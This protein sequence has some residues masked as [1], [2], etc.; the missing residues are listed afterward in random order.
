MIYS[1]RT[2]RSAVFVDFNGDTKNLLRVPFMQGAFS[3]AWLQEL[4]AKHPELLQSEEIGSEYSQLVCIGREVKVGSG[5]NTGYIDN[6]YV[7]SSGHIVVV[8]TKLFRNQEARRTVVAQII[9]YAKDLQRWDCEDLDEVASDYSYRASG[10]AYRAFD[11]MLAA[12]YLT[13]AD[14]ARFIDAVNRN[15]KAANFLLLIVGDGIRSGVER[16]A[17]FITSYS[18]LPF[19]LGLLEL[20]VYQHSSG[21]VV[22]PNMLT[23]TSVIPIHRAGCEVPAAKTEA[24]VPAAVLPTSEF[25]KIFAANG[26]YDLETIAAFVSDLCTIPGVSY[27]VHPTEIRF[28]I[29]VDGATIPFLIFGKSGSAGRPAADIWLCPDEIIN[30]LTKSGRLPTDADDYLDFYRAYIDTA[31]CKHR[32]YDAPNGFYYADVLRVVTDSTGFMEAVER[33]ISAISE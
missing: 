1:E 29:S 23:K 19:N 14:S 33:F 8:E 16:L 5:E 3:E 15:L 6:L 24:K 9:D 21:M 30:K 25:L 32:P 4:I 27:T 10:Q 31:R 18:A 20:E 26:G 22:I 13:A 17:E 12:G 7:S 28:R 11:M 2:N